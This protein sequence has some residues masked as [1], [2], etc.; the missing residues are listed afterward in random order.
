MSDNGRHPPSDPSDNELVARVGRRDAVA[1]ELLY[2]RYARP[3]YAMAAHLLGPA[4]AED[5]VQEVFLRLWRKADQFDPTRGAFRTWFMAIARHHVLH[6]QS[7]H[8]RQQRLTAAADIDQILATTADDTIDV[9]EQAWRRER[10]ETAWRALGG[11]PA[12]QR[13]VLVL[14]YFG[15][16]SQAAIADQLRLPLGTVKKRTRLG[17]HKLRDA[18][19]NQDALGQ[20]ADPSLRRA[21]RT[22]VTDEV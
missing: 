2:D 3:V 13:L 14:A 5:V 8:G 4:R 20:E 16:L 7:G 12:E 11:L 9:E 19:A 21:A 6:E 15:G 1:F 22:R 18:L 17:L 10:G